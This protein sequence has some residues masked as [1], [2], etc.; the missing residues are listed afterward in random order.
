MQSKNENWKSDPVSKKQLYVLFNLTKKD[1]KNEN[2]TKGEASDIIASYMKDSESAQQKPKQKILTSDDIFNS[3]KDYTSEIMT[4]IN[5]ELGIKSTL[6]NDFDSTQQ[7]TFVGSGCGFA[8]VKYDKRSKLAGKIFGSDG[9]AYA[10]ATKFKKHLLDTQFTNEA[11]SHYKSIGAPLEATMYQ[12]MTIN[13]NI[14]VTIV[15]IVNSV[16]NIK[17]LRVECRLD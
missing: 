14:L 7:Y 12:N 15:K 17:S 1:Y 9:V 6:V 10:A 3:L 8:W 4:M 13:C 16:Y 5:G 11:K 2:L